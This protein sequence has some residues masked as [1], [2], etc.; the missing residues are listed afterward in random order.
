MA[1]V[2]VFALLCVSLYSY[3][4]KYFPSSM[5]VVVGYTDPYLHPLHCAL[6]ICGKTE[7][8]VDVASHVGQ[9]VTPEAPRQPQSPPPPTPPPTDSCDDDP[10]CTSIVVISNPSGAEIL[11]NEK[12]TGLVTPSRVEVPKGLFSITIRKRGYID[13]RSRDTT[14]EKIGHRLTANLVKLNVAYLDIDVFPPQDAVISINGKRL[15]T[16]NGTIRELP[17]QAN[18]PLKVRAETK[19][20]G[21]YDE[22]TVN[23]PVD[24]RQSVQLNPR[25]TLR[26]PSNSPNE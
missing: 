23:L 6:G 9:P 1:S 24:R 26:V 10:L 8:K 20:G 22:I 3:M 17:V 2:M 11:I 4:I 25:K 16:K 15:T 18:T 7:G 19:N 14:R 5:Q 12:S 13:A 21:S